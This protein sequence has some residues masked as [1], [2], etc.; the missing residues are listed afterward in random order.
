MHSAEGI[1]KWMLTSMNY[2]LL[3]KTEKVDNLGMESD[4]L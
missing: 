3:I 1:I 4:I 2:K